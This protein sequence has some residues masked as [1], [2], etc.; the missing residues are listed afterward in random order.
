[1]NFF[2][3]RVHTED[4]ENVKLFLQRE[5]ATG[6]GVREEAGR[7]H[8]H[9]ALCVGKTIVALRKSFKRSFPGMRGNKDYSLE[10]A[11]DWGK[12][13]RYCA[14][15]EARDSGPNVIWSYGVSH[16]PEHISLFHV[17]YWA[18]NSTLA[19]QKRKRGNIMVET[20]KL[21][22]ERKIAWNDRDGITEIYAE[23]VKDAGKTYDVNL[24]RRTVRGIM[25]QLCPND[26]FKKTMV[27]QTW[28]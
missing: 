3:L 11:Q 15:G 10:E 16:Q 17:Q 21:C 2:H 28:Y 8:Y 4:I 25:I 19:A 7:V 23:M 14:K 6:F 18:E 9:F 12:L 27:E 24:A 1:M 26:S 20:E 13:Q 5:N 22:R